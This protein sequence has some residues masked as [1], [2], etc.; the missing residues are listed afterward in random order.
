M[1]ID[2][3]AFAGL[4]AWQGAGVA[5]P[6]GVT[7]DQ[8][9]KLAKLDWNVETAEIVTNDQKRTNVDDHRVTRRIEDNAI[10]GVVRKRYKPIQNAEAFGL[11]EGVARQGRVGFTAAG[12]MRGGSRVFIVA[13]MPDVLEVGK[14]IGNID[15]VERYLLLSNAHDGS[16]PLQMVFTPVRVVCENTLNMALNVKK[17][18]D[19]KTRMA[20]RVRILHNSKAAFQMKQAEKAMGA[21]L[22]YYTKFGEFSEALYRK[23]VSGGQV[24]NIVNE[25]F[26]PN[27]EKEVTPAIAEHRRQVE[28]LFVA[29]KGHD[30]IAG[31]A[32][33]L[34]NAFA[35]YA[36][37]GFAIKKAVKEKEPSERAY[38]IWMGGSQNLKQRANNVVS[39][40]VL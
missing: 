19:K 37:H 28:N 12:E 31:S 21:A 34:I 15:V 16:R 23:Q 10:L 35:E 6:D 7:A 38:S 22:V 20:P 3:K 18:G 1:S 40:A 9:I 17:T 36:D 5:L 11:F 13:K 30:K 8:A 32:W 39:E 29:G 27:K 25:V 2:I 24:T 33:A 4:S 26:P 14:G